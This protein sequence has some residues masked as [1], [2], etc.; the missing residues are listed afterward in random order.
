MPNWLHGVLDRDDPYGH[1]GLEL[2][3]GEAARLAA[4]K[5]R[6]QQKE[7]TM[8][9]MKEPGGTLEAKIL[10]ELEVAPR[11][12][13]DIVEKYKQYSQS[14]VATLMSKL[15]ARGLVRTERTED[16]Q[17]KLRYFLNREPE[18]QPAAPPRYEVP[19]HAQKPASTLPTRR[20][21]EKLTG[22]IMEPGVKLMVDGVAVIA[23]TAG[24]FSL[25]TG[26][27]VV[28]TDA[29]LLGAQRIIGLS[30]KVEATVSV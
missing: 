14:S 1:V 30:V 28:A 18:P 13:S 2:T 6:K 7:C 19:E 29:E 10:K 23:T 9:A 4:I 17:R 27:P 8:G 20:V 12:L 26:L 11:L 21:M 22:V 16:D 15:K 25:K 24:L 5:Q 3:E